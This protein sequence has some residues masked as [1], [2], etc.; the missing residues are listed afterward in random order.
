MGIGSGPN[1][2]N[3]I[4]AADHDEL[5]FDIGELRSRLTEERAIGRGVIIVY[6]LGEVNTGGMGTGLDEVASLCKEYQAWLHIDAGE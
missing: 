4:P 6:G 5:A 2:I 1:V 3:T